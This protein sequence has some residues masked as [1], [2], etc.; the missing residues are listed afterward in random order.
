ME[1]NTVEA[2]QI[3]GAVAAT[4][5]LV[6]A[7]FLKA[8]IIVKAVMI[9]LF[10]ASI[11]CWAIIVEKILRLRKLNS[12]AEKFE[13]TIPQEVKDQRAAEVMELQEQISLEKN[14]EKVG[15]TFKT[16]IDREEGEYFIG[17]TEGDSPEVDNEVLIKGDE[18]ELE[19]GEFYQVKIV[20]ADAY[21]IYGELVD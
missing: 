19:I 10:V 9:F 13:D 18:F 2:A 12:S 4:D 11:W 14:E 20:S 3:I 7:L 5:F 15:K 16:L 17:R 21:D 1:G 6:W 8:D